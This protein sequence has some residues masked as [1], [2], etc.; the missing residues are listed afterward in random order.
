MYYFISHF[1]FI[2]IKYLLLNS[3]ES[4]FCDKTFKH[5]SKWFISAQN[6]ANSRVHQSQACFLHIAHLCIFKLNVSNKMDCSKSN[7]I[8]WRVSCFFFTNP[9]LY[10]TKYKYCG[11]FLCSI[12]FFIFDNEM[13]FIDFKNYHY[14][15]C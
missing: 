5:F 9:K 15:K 6:N 7:I 2:P 1:V 4:T 10:D 14:Q 12:F 11:F 13:C 8:S 3:L